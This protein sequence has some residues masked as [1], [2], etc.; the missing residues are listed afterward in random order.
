VLLRWR[1]QGDRVL[2]V[3]NSDGRFVKMVARKPRWRRRLGHL[4]SRQGFAVRRSGPIRDRFAGSRMNF[5]LAAIIFS[6]IWRAW[7]A[8]WPAVVGR[9]AADGSAAAD[10]RAATSWA[11]STDVR[12]PSGRISIVGSRHRRAPVRLTV[13]RG[14]ERA[15]GSR[16]RRDAPCPPTDLQEQREV[17]DLGAGPQSH[18]R[19]AP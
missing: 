13:V 18:R 5:V 16:S 9:V 10:L 8:V 17:W 12:S 7:D 19:S 2:S 6:V 14:R 3:G 1:S 11:R 4:R 15:G